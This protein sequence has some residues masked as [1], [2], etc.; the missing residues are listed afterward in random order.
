MASWLLRESGAQHPGSVKRFE[1]GVY[2]ALTDNPVPVGDEIIDRGGFWRDIEWWHRDAEHL[3][4][5][6]QVGMRVLVRGNEIL[7]TWD[8]CQ[9]SALKIQASRIAIL[10]VRLSSVTMK[11][12]EHEA[13]SE[14]AADKDQQEPPAE[15]PME[16]DQGKR[17]NAK[18]H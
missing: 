7:D 9:K 14:G 17:G 10:P 13:K 6:F 2:G 3:A 8:D 18:K 15:A 4:S 12:K 5:L 1:C 16:Q 11:P